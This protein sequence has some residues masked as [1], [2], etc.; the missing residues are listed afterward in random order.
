MSFDELYKKEIEHIINNE[1]PR[2][3]KT[4]ESCFDFKRWGFQMIY[5]GSVSNA[6]PTIVYE[7]RI[8]R[9][10]FI[11]EV[12]DM[13]SRSEIIYILY[14]RLHAPVFQE[15]MDWNGEKCYCWHDVD[16]VLNFLDGLA[17]HE[18]SNTPVFKRNFNEANKNRG[19]RP[20]EMQAQRQAAIWERYGQRLFDIFDLN[21]PDLWQQYADFVKEHFSNGIIWPGNSE[22]PPL[23]KIC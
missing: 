20:S 18:A 7:S 11:W 17:P 3:I 15:V 2:Y 16:K 23:H 10:R 1:F 22:Y 19:W 21:H 13:R 9:V 4:L 6:H 12:P 8:C 14:G 5:S